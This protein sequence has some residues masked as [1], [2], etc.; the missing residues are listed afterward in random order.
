MDNR[1]FRTVMATALLLIA[2]AWT[3]GA[4]AQSAKQL[5]KKESG[6]VR[7]IAFTNSPVA[8]ADIVVSRL[9]G[10]VVFEQDQA[11]NA[12]GF[13][14][15]EIHPVPKNFRVTVT[16]EAQAP[17]RSLGLVRM[18][19]DVRNYDP[20]H[21]EVYVNPVTTMVSRLLDRRPEL[22]L[23]R[24]Q[25]IVRFVLGMPA[26]ASLGAAMREGPYYQSPVFSESEFLKRANAYG[27][28]DSYL[29]NL[30]TQAIYHPNE[31]HLFR[32]QNTQSTQLGGIATTVATELA[33]G[34]ISWL[35]GKGMGWAAAQ[36]GL[37][38]PGATKDDILHL[39]T[40]LEGLQSSVD[41]LSNQ[42]TRSTAQINAAINFADYNTLS[43][44]ALKLAAQVNV[45]NQNVT[46]LAD[47][48]PPIPE[49]QPPVTPTKYCLS[50]EA[51]ITSQL[52]ESE[53]DAS[54]E[55]FAAFLE[56]T[57]T[58]GNKGMLHLFSLCVGESVGHFFRYGDSAKIW[59]MWDYWDDV[60]TQAAIAKVE[61]LHLQD[62][63]DDP[64]GRKVLIRF[65]GDANVIPPTDGELQNTHNA[66]AAL[67]WPILPQGTVINTADK[68]HW[69]TTLP[70]VPQ[71]PSCRNAITSPPN[72]TGGVNTVPIVDDTKLIPYP[73]EDADL[74]KSPSQSQ[75]ASLID[76]W[77][78]VSPY[79]GKWI[80]DQTITKPGDPPGVDSIAFQALYGSGYISCTSDGKPWVWTVT[81]ITRDQNYIV[82]NMTDGNPQPSGSNVGKVTNWNFIFVV[83]GFFRQYYWFD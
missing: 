71:A 60:E 83:S 45:V 66:E 29:E 38:T 15:A 35:G 56:D 49:G 82:I 13:Y 48:C 47:A 65:L 34:A 16:W 80:H 18:S 20:V 3:V 42:L 41:A 32:V 24:A 6:W 44:Q 8:K 59:Q 64:G 43:I 46:D 14:P 68:S 77:K 2:G 9:N 7:I 40:Q 30:V 22:G 26:N 54:F 67:V 79:P 23:A 1:K 17:Y 39:Q 73:G 19:T 21:G 10:K 36:A 55:E 52:N 75:L 69:M 57:A 72:G 63:Q 62:A 76:G 31:T 28:F 61:R 4:S 5:A 78:D 11:T 70:G 33:K 12:R 58:V 27:G 37:S 51:T 25:A 74:Y 53:I 50:L 81:Y